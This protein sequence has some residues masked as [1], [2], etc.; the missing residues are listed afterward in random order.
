MADPGPPIA[1]AEIN[2]G[3][4]TFH[5]FGATPEQARAALMAAWLQHVT[6]TGADLDCFPREDINVIEGGYGRAFRDGSPYPRAVT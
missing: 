4:F 6:D 1:L 3:H 2:T 5:A